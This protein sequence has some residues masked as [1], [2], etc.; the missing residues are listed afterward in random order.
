V[1]KLEVR[2]CCHPSKVLGHL[3]HPRLQQFGD[4]W[5]FAVVDRE[6]DAN[7]EPRGVSIRERASYTQLYLTVERIS[8]GNGVITEAIKNRDYPLT[9]LKL[10]TGFE[11]ATWEPGNG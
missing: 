10:I 2:C 5:T 9:T 7:W 4:S 6:D 3:A 8:D 11:P 1:K